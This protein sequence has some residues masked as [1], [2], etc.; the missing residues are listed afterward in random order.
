MSFGGLIVL[1]AFLLIAEK[2]VLWHLRLS[3]RLSSG[4]DPGPASQKLAFG[5]VKLP[6]YAAFAGL[7]LVGEIGL[8]SKALAGGGLVA[9]FVSIL[10][11]DVHEFFKRAPR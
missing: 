6:F 5:R 9:C 3:E 2:K 1:G 4:N 7:A 10:F 8:L 11:L